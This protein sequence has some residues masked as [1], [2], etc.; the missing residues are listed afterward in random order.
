[1]TASPARTLPPSITRSSATRPTAMPTRSKPVHDVLELRGLAAGDRDAGRSGALAQARADGVEHGG[2][3][4]LDR[5]VVDQRE[6]RGADADHVVDVHRDAVDADGVV[7]AHHVGDH[8]LG[9]DA[10]GAEREPDPS[11]SITL[12]K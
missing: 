7:F 5:D 3:G 4:A 12:A 10:V 2:V 6:R 9:A 1:M 8:G 11:S